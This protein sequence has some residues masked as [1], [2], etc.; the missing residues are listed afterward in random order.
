[1]ETMTD[2]QLIISLIKDDLINSKLV[3]G[4]NEM[5]LNANPYF[6]HLGETVFNLMGIEETE[7]TEYLFERYIELSKTAMYADISQSHDSLDNLALQI[8][9]ELNEFLSV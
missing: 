8:Y 6:L 4:L 1:M 3:T 5:G 9:N 7:E 2:K